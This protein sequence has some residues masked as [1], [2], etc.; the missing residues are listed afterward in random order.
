MLGKCLGHC[1]HTESPKSTPAHILILNNIV[2]VMMLMVFSARGLPW[3]RPQQPCNFLGRCQ[4]PETL[5][6]KGLMWQAGARPSYHPLPLPGPWGAQMPGSSDWL[7]SSGP[8]QPWLRH[9]GDSGGFLIPVEVAE[10]VACWAMSRQGGPQADR[11]QGGSYWPSPCLQ[12]GD[13]TCPHG[14]CG[15]PGLPCF[16]AQ[17]LLEPLPSTAA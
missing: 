16:L 8:S 10:P 17:F 6:D 13:V 2:L 7:G 11:V 14:R 1:S 3:I 15:I 5:G 12:Q 9:A 4:R